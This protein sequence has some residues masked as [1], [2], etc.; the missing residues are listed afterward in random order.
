[1][2]IFDKIRNSGLGGSIRSEMKSSSF[3]AIRSGSGDVNEAYLDLMSVFRTEVQESR[4][5]TDIHA[6]R[7]RMYFTLCFYY[8]ASSSLYDEWPSLRSI[9][10]EGRFVLYL[11]RNTDYEGEEAVKMAQKIAGEVRNLQAVMDAGAGAMYFW[12][13]EN[14]LKA[15]GVEL[16]SICSMADRSGIV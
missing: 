11:I 1:M 16:D 9:P 7:V 10:H 15:A 12:L 14:D 2:G 8:G 13:E 3:E 4:P 6:S 5:N